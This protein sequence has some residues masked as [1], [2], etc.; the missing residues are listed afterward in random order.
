MEFENLT[1]EK[2]VAELEKV[3]ARLEKGTLS[4]EQSLELYEKGMK[5]SA[6]CHDRLQNAKLRLEE[7]STDQEQ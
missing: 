7:I 4:L 1:F 6:V 2:A 3:V 5:L